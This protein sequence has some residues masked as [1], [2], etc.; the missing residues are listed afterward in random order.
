MLGML[1]VALEQLEPGREKLLQLAIVRR[2]NERLAKAV[3]HKLVISHLVLRVG[4]VELRA[5]ERAHLLQLIVTL[6]GQ[7]AAGLVV[8][9]RD[10]Q[11]LHECQR[12]LIDSL[13]I[14]D[15][16]IS[17]G[18]DVLVLGVLF[19]EFRGLDVDLAS[20]VGDVSDLRVGRLAGRLRHGRTR[21][22]HC[23]G[24]KGYPGQRHGDLLRAVL[25]LQA[26]F[27][28]AGAEGSRDTQRLRGYGR[29]PYTETPSE[30]GFAK[31]RPFS[32]YFGTLDG[33]CRLK[34]A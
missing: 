16:V 12:L 17:E 14:A 6:L 9:G 21:N 8:L 4:S 22:D 27:M 7:R 18:E 32:H 25:D 28:Q 33:G 31:A 30:T 19:G 24:E 34:R 23:G 13:V 5:L 26:P 2:R 15:H 10:I 1:L 29:R 3:V 20:R 11:L